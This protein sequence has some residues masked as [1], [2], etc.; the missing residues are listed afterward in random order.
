MEPENAAIVSPVGIFVP[1]ICAPTS[2]AVTVPAV[3]VTEVVPLSVAVKV[4]P[5]GVAAHF[6]TTK[7]VVV[8]LYCRNA[9]FEPVASYEITGDVETVA[10]PV[11]NAQNTVGT[12]TV[13][14]AGAPQ[15]VPDGPLVP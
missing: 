11:L 4:L 12:V 13:G 1:E 14:L 15:P 2:A 7:L 5:A 3:T 8:P 9:T 10:A 6:T